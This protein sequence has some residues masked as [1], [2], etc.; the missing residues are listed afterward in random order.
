MG[1]RADKVEDLVAGH[2]SEKGTTSTVSPT[3]CLKKSSR[4]DRNLAI[5][6]MLASG[7]GDTAEEFV[8]GHDKEF[9]RFPHRLVIHLPGAQS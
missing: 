7:R 9:A 1:G 3:F 2:A 8:A 6:K 5:P 4:Q